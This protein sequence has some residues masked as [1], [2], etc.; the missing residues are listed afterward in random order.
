[1]RIENDREIF[2][3][4]YAGI[5]PFLIEEY[6]G[7]VSLEVYA[8]AEEAARVYLARYEG[9]LFS[10]E[11]LSFVA[12]SL[13]R[14][15][16][17]NR[18]ERDTVGETLYYD[19]YELTDDASLEPSLINGATHRL[20][21]SLLKGIKKNLTTFS[22]DELLAKRLAAFVVVE[23]GAVVA[24]ATVNERL[25]R[26]RVLEVTVETAPRFRQKGYALSTVTA[27]SAYLLDKGA[28]VAYCCRHTH[29]KSKRVARRVGFVPVGRFYAVSAYRLPNAD[30]E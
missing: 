9:R 6:K 26:G 20:T 2:D 28:T 16:L 21:A 18:Y 25:K 27:L 7:E 17:A 1:M 15:L 8:G 19:Q 3:A 11:A 23:E 4:G 13:D 29:T 24:I 10:K 22:L 12:R 5:V 14:Y 30:K